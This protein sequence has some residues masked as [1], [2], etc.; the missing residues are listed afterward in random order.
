VAQLIVRDL[1]PE[2]VTRKVKHV[3]WTGVSHLNRFDPDGAH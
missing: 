2:L 3:A 1:D